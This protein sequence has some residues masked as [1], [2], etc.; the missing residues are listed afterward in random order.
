MSIATNSLVN[1]SLHSTTSVT[2]FIAQVLSSKVKVAWPCT[3]GLDPAIF[4]S[5]LPDI[6]VTCT[7]GMDLL[8]Q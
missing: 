8:K 2:I 5:W 7:S 4:I 1:I 3:K 6:P